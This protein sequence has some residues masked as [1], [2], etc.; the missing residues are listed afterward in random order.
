[1]YTKP[2]LG[3]CSTVYVLERRAF[4]NCPDSRE[5]S[6]ASLW[7][8]IEVIFLPKSHSAAHIAL[9]ITSRSVNQTLLKHWKEQISWL[10]HIWGENGL[11]WISDVL[12]V[13]GQTWLFFWNYCVVSSSFFLYNKF[14][15]LLF[16]VL[17]SLL[18][19]FLKLLVYLLV[20]I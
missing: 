5:S 2:H 9:I 10:E 11:L 19:D 17:V 14:Y 6:S 15:F 20:Y 8:L 16:F 4:W 12:S 3:M 18:Y 1:M 13:H 7:S